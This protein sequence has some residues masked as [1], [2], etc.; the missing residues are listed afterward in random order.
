MSPSEKFLK[1][2]LALQLHTALRSRMMVSLKYIRRDF[3]M[4]LGC[5]FFGS[6][7]T[8]RG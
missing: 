6:V 3:L 8:R 5:S 7:A 2:A 1:E 4:L